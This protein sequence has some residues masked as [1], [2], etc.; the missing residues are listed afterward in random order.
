MA[1]YWYDHVHLT[2][3]D[4]L[5]AAEFYEKMLGAKRVGVSELPDGRTRVIL[6]LNGLVIRVT[7]PGAEPLVANAS[8]TGYGLDHLGLRTDNLE[9]AVDELKTK[10]VKFVQDITL[11]RP[12]VKMSFFLS[13]EP[14]NVLIEL[15]ELQETGG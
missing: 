10:G 6:D 11:V 15:L 2:S 8:Q 9:V 14:E 7:H 5:K 12:G 1:N 3:P 13:P 4:P